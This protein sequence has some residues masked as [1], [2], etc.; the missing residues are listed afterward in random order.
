MTRTVADAALMLSVMAGPDDWDAT[1]LEAPP[2]DYVGQLDGG[3]RGPAHRV[4]PRLSTRC[5]SI[6]RS[7]ARWRPPRAP[8]N[9]SAPSVEEVK[10]GFADSHRHDPADLGRA[11]HRQLR[12][13]P[14]RSGAAGWTRASSPAWTRRS[15]APRQDY[16]AMRGRKIAYWD[17]VRP[18][19]E[20]YDLLLTPTTSVAA[21]QVG[22]L[23][24]ERLAAARV[25]LVPLGV[26]LATR[27]T[28]P[29]SRP[30]RCRPASR[31]AGCRSGCRSS[32]AASPT[33]PCSRPRAPSRPRGPG[34]T[35][36]HPRA[37]A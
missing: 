9:R 19:F 5:A 11:L 16:V 14:R 20:R 2:A 35:A 4:Q 8:S 3:V 17:S 25:G 37:E 7:P 12:P 1:C 28:S 18:L 26:V 13:V 30:P 32:A 6:P 27:S 15:A 22:R 29:A 24:P 34:R 33:S 10:P 31:R 23:N 36:N 21:F